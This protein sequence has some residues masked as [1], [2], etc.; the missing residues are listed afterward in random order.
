MSATPRQTHT[1]TNRERD[2]Q[3]TDKEHKGGVEENIRLG[4]RGRCSWTMTLDSS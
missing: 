3:G 4:W 1:D 2:K